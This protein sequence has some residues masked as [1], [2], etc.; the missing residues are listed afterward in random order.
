MSKQPLPTVEMLRKLLIHDVKLGTLTWNER[1]EL[2][3]KTDRSYNTWNTRYAGKEAFTAT[4]T[5]G[6]KV[7]A[8]HKNFTERIE[9]FGRFIMAVGRKKILTT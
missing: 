6:Y 1:D 4:D 7:G 5:Y 2:M 8:I 3:F 9:L